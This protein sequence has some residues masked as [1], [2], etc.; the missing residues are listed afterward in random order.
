LKS[1]ENPNPS[2]PP[3]WRRITIGVFPGFGRKRKNWPPPKFS[4]KRK[5][6]QGDMKGEADHIPSLRGRTKENKGKSQPK[7]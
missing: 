2:R 7:I 3:P 4:L 1:L 5:S 6:G